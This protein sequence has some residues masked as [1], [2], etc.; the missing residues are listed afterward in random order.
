MKVTA[1]GI[2]FNC[3]IDGPEGAPWL[4][5]SNSIATNLHMW[6]GQA[7]ALRRAFRILR[8]DKRG[9][10]GTE[11][12]QGPYDFTMLVEDVVGLWNALDIDKSHFVGLSMGGMTALGLGIHH[13]DRVSSLVVS[14]AVGEASDAF[15]ASWEERI[16]LVEKNGVEPVVPM[17]VERFFSDAFRAAGSPAVDALA[18]VVASTSATGLIGC[19]RALQGLDFEARM[20]EITTPTLFIAGAQDIPTPAET[21]RRIAKLVPGARYVELSPAGHIA[22]IEQ[23]EAYNAALKDFLGVA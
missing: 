6:D 21:M 22:N 11:I 1:N 2:A 23:P 3:Q 13:A 17:M 14:N 9:H 12:V 18:A 15:R 19:G 4:T 5:F 8:Y 10:G 20:S 16:A 7:A